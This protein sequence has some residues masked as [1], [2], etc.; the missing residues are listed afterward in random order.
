MP[1]LLVVTTVAET[2]R[3]FLFPYADHFRGLGWRV[4]GMANGVGSGGDCA[5]HFDCVYDIDWSRRPLGNLP[6]GRILQRVRE[7]AASGSYDI[8]HVHTPIA[9]FLTRLAIA[10]GRSAKSP[11]M[12]YTA[13]GFHF[14]KGNH[15]VANLIY[16]AAEK[17]AARWTDYL[18][19][20]ND[21][22]RLTALR[23]GIVPPERLRPMPGIGV[24]R[25]I[26]CRS[27]IDPGAVAEVR[28]GFGIPGDAPVFVMIAEFQPRKRHWDV[29]QAFASMQNRN[30]HMIFVGRGKGMKGIQT[31]AGKSGAGGR[32]HFA[33]QQPDVR[34]FILTARAV[35][36]PSRREGLPRSVMESMCC[37]VPV[38]GSDIPGMRDLLADGGGSL[39]PC[40]DVAA[41]TGHLDWYAANREQ[42]AETGRLASERMAQY[43]TA[44]IIRMHEELYATA[45]RDHA[46]PPPQDPVA[47]SAERTTRSLPANQPEQQP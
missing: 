44:N 46:G 40:G 33:G 36:L 24:D 39:F 20:M 26:Y 37:G 14:Q 5:A 13:H 45:L 29:V 9:A 31:L 17:L 30:C 10:P 6:A 4:D 7:I 22:D 41:L 43:D 25:A 28:R 3:A 1:R 16:A 18:V 8:V 35:V 34:P 23:L 12:I 21:A 2:L 42:A 47:L 15:T 27:F 19:T 38:I 32:I 11:C